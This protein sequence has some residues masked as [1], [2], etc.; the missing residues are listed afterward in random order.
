M[1]DTTELYRGMIMRFNGEPHVLI[2]KEFYSP[3][4]GSAFNKCKLKNIKTGKVYHQIFKSGEK[5]DELEVQTRNMQFLYADETDAYFM[6]NE[7]FEQIGVNLDLIPE[8][9]G[10]LHQDAKYTMSIFE[11]QVIT[12]QLPP[13]ISLIVTETSDVVKGNTVSNA[14]KEA[15]M[16]TGL[17][18]QVPLFIKT[19]DKLIIN[20][21]SGTYFSKENK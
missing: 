1:T 11:D 14:S 21:D 18:V 5:V 9:T 15:T 6:S 3:A 2:E 20:T 7:T 17:K 12:V 19:G 10:Y 8:R 4:K 13:K 16:E